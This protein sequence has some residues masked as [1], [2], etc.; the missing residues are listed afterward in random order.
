MTRR[1]READSRR[2]ITRASAAFESGCS[3]IAQSSLPTQSLLSATGR[4][5]PAIHSEDNL[6][7]LFA[8]AFCA[9]RE[10]EQANQYRAQGGERREG[11]RE[12]RKKN[13]PFVLSVSLIYFFPS[14]TTD[15]SDCS[16]QSD[17]SE[18]ARKKND[19]NCCTRFCRPRGFLNHTV[20]SFPSPAPF[21]KSDHRRCRTQ[22][23]RPSPSSPCSTM[24]SGNHRLTTTRITRR[25][26]RSLFRTS[27]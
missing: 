8:S 12:N 10:N 15:L 26:R 14:A 9:G 25:T 2:K 18:A 6:E 5:F 16:G 3:P 7:Y 27:L 11:R 1:Q 13:N 24:S 17:R 4:S 23:R 20:Y 19:R 21:D 22:W